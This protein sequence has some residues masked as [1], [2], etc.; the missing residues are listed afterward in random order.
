MVYGSA[1][2]GITIKS[3]SKMADTIS[4]TCYQFF[5]TISEEKAAK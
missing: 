1:G 5:R 4:R 2:T 3:M